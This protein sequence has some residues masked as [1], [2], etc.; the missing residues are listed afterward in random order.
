M[1]ILVIAG[2]FE[3]YYNFR[4]QREIVAGKQQL[5]AKQA[6]HAVEGFIQV[7]FSLLEAA[8]RLGDPASVSRNNQKRILAKLLGL[9]P[10]FRQIVLL[11]SQEQEIAKISRLSQAASGNLIERIE[12]EA[13]SQVEEGNR[14]IGS[15]YVDEVTNEPLVVIASPV[16]GIFGDF[17][18]TLMAEVNLKFMWDLVDRLK[19]GEKGLAYVVDRQGD[20]I[21]FGDI[22]RVLQGQNLSYLKEVDEFINSR[23][24]V[25]ETRADISTGINKA[26]IVG[27]Y[28]PLGTPDWAVVIELPVSEAYR[29]VIRAVLISV[30]A[31]LIVAI[32]A[33]LA[34]FIVARRLADP[35][36]DLT[37]TA[38][39]IAGGEIG[40]R[41]I[42]QGPAE[43]ERLARAFNDM[44]GQLREML[45]QEEDRSRKMQQEI[46]QR[47]R[48]EEALRKSEERYR[49]LVE[50]MNEGLGVMDAN[51]VMTYVNDKLCNMIGYSKDE[52]VG[53]LL[54]NFFDEENQKILEEQVAIRRKGEPG[55]YEL[56]WTGKDGSKIPAIISSTPLYDADGSF[57]GSLAVVTDVAERKR[58]EEA[59][60]Q[61]EYRYRSIFE[62]VS[63]SLL[64]EDL[65][66]FRSAIEMLKAEGVNDF[67]KYLEEH[68]EFVV[69]AS[70]KIKVKDMNDATLRLFGAKSKEELLGSLEKIFVEESLP[71][72]KN[73]IIAL[74]EGRT[75]FQTEGVNQNLQGERLHVL[76]KMRVTDENEQYNQLLV[77]IMDITDR[78][79]AE[80]ELQRYREHLE[81][82]V[83]E[84]TRELEIAQEELLKRERLAVLGQLTAT[85]SH[86]LRNP[87]GTIR[88]SNFFLQ[89][90]VKEKDEKILK[91]FSRID[92]QV[93]RCDTIVE[94]LL[95]YTRGRHVDAVK[96]A[97][98][99][100]LD[101]LLDQLLESENIKITRYFPKDL[102][103]V[104]YDQEKMRRV[105]VNVIDNAIQSVKAKNQE[106]SSQGAA[107]RPEIRVVTSSGDGGLLIEIEDN[108]I[109]MDGQTLERAFEPLYT[110]RARGTGLGL[111]NVRKIITEHGGT[112]TIESNPEEG[113]RVIIVLPGRV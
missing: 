41:A 104:Y 106:C 43:V 29:E 100:W 56:S 94:E 36:L 76:L 7:K 107:F 26:T 109:G 95:E 105:I 9:Q 13:F 22:G 23:S 4:T 108:G 110:T 8:V 50:K 58:M 27:T 54:T 71:M 79:R 59:L 80:D 92:Q 55:S 46:V 52:I 14:Y 87:L 72:F 5:I 18:G 86:E 61:S 112:V 91:H 34:G 102:P 16:T 49:L 75:D 38:S 78:K 84:R 44:T 98:N 81:D 30:G 11:D 113:T 67:R 88:S 28:V 96:A 24:S 2:S 66:E 20:L 74:A 53:Q 25:D 1:A 83:K 40:L 6:A 65:S 21:A 101:E 62:T 17:R 47:S 51:R 63:V 60:R 31:I 68:P 82:L 93:G 3:V 69:E 12:K 37:E 111:A 33:G 10:A 15:V 85:V 103:E 90:K 19:I 48:A 42:I 32:L 57:N 35:L 99:P 70:N 64:E 77:S 45:G 73:L 97:I 89:R 39:R